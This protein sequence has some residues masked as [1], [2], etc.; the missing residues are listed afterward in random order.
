MVTGP[1]FSSRKAGRY[2]VARAWETCDQNIAALRTMGRAMHEST[3]P[4]PG[5]GSSVM[6]AMEWDKDDSNVNWYYKTGDNWSKY[7]SFQT[8]EI[9]NPYFNLGVIW[10]G[11][12]FSNPDSSK[13]YFFQA[14]VSTSS[15]ET[16]YGQITFECPAYYDRQEEKHCLQFAAVERGNSHGRCC[17]SGAC[18]TISEG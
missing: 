3:V 12:P 15:Q 4:L 8:P 7:S 17:G 9:E 1:T 14:G 18:K 10:V 6:L 5:N 11:N 16:R 13:A 2:L